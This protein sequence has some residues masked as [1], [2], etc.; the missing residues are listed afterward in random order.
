MKCQTKKQKKKHDKSIL[1]GAEKRCRR[2]REPDSDEKK[3]K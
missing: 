2:Q 3:I 1:D